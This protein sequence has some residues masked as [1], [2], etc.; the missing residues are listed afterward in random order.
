MSGSGFIL[1]LQ[2]QMFSYSGT[3]FTSY[4]FSTEFLLDCQTSISHSAM[5]GRRDKVHSFFPHE[6]IHEGEGILLYF[7]LF[8]IEFP[9][10]IL[11]PAMLLSAQIFVK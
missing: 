7:P 4:P 9:A 3:F 1:G 5:E 6:M 10:C 8:V 2:L 11:V